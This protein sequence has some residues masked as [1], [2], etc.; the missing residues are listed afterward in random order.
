MTATDRTRAIVA[1]HLQLMARL[2]DRL[3]E[4]APDDLAAAIPMAITGYRE[5]IRHVARFVA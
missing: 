3:E 5:Y 4:I 1:K 2:V